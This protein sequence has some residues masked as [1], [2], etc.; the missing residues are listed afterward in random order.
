MV[1]FILKLAVEPAGQITQR[2]GHDLLGVFGRR[3]PG[4]A[5]PRDVNG[6]GVFVVVAATVAGLGGEL[7]EVPPLDGL[8]PVSDTMQSGIRRSVVSDARGRAL[9]VGPVAFERR[10]MPSTA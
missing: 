5:V 8:Q 3:L 10:I 7:V 1:V 9:G 2:L 6:H 4:R